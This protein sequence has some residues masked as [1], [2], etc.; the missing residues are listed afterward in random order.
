MYGDP[1]KS[2]VE[3]QFL[4]FICFLSLVSQNLRK[5][6]L[7]NKIRHVTPFIFCFERL[8]MQ[9]DFSDRE[10]PKGATMNIL[11]NW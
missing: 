5:F 8:N 11:N 9:M 6:A 10:L 2:I 3:R 4:F 7:G 1:H